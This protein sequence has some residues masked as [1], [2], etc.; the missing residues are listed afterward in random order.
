MVIAS[1]AFSLPMSFATCLT[2]VV[3]GPI[4]DPILEHFIEKIPESLGDVV[5]TLSASE[6]AALG[7]NLS[8][9]DGGE[10]SCLFGNRIVKGGDVRFRSRPHHLRDD[11]GIEGP[12]QPPGHPLSSSA[13]ET[14]LQP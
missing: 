4:D 10:T 7:R 12:S 8:D 5:A 3:P 14:G 6:T 13:N 11:V 9:G 1:P 2:L